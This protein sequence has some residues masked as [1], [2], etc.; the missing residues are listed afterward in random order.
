M[1]AALDLSQGRNPA[2]ELPNQ[3]ITSGSRASGVAAELTNGRHARSYFELL[4]GFA[5]RNIEVASVSAT[6]PA[7]YS[8]ILTKGNFSEL[9]PL[10]KMALTFVHQPL[11]QND[12]PCF[13]CGPGGNHVCENKKHT[14]DHTAE[15]AMPLAVYQY[16]H[17]AIL[18][19]RGGDE[20]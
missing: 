14:C 12:F 11:L 15:M 1:D 19:R 5:P 17:G 2:E 3:A 10:I 18:G 7:I 13:V 6:Q 9:H 4:V 16:W 20:V 8:V